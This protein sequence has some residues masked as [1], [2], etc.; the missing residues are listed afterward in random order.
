MRTEMEAEEIPE[1][2]GRKKEIPELEALEPGEFAVFDHAQ[3]DKVRGAASYI[4]RTTGRRFV[5]RS[6][7]EGGADGEMCK[8]FKVWRKEE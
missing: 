6:V 7:E 2:R 3:A 8:V 1:T 5:T 4:A